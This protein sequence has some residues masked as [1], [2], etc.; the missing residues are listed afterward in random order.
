MHVKI[1]L[2]I[3]NKDENECNI[4]SNALNISFYKNKQNIIYINNLQAILI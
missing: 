1:I 2:Q 3:Q 4:F